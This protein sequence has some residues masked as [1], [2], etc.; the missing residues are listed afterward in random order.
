MVFCCCF[1]DVQ[2]QHTD[3]LRL[4]FNQ[5]YFMEQSQ[6]TFEKRLARLQEVVAALETGELALEKGVELFKEGVTLAKGCRTEL[7]QARKDVRL[8]SQNMWKDFE[9]Q[10][11]GDGSSDGE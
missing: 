5:E 10:G 11:D 8:Y 2:R 6:D 9:D 7:M 3:V 1:F 4:F